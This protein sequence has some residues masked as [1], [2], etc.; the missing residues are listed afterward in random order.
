MATASGGIA[1]KSVA[2]TWLQSKYVR[3]PVLLPEEH[4]TSRVARV[5]TRR[6]AITISLPVVRRNIPAGSCRAAPGCASSLFD[7]LPAQTA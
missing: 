6:G 5:R 2:E 7:A 4:M 1:S 3:T